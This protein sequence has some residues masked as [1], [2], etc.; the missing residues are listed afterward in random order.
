M[1]GKQDF[2]EV[3]ALVDKL[4]VLLD[5]SGLS[6]NALA[7][8]A[9]YDK[10]TVSRFMSGQFHPQWDFMETLMDAV[11]ERR[12]LSEEET[13]EVL[14]VWEEALFARNGR[15]AGFR[16][17]RKT[18][19]ELRAARGELGSKLEAL[20]NKYHLL[21]LAGLAAFLLVVWMGIGWY[22]ADEGVLKSF[23]GDAPAQEVNCANRGCAVTALGWVLGSSGESSVRT[24][25]EVGTYGGTVS[26]GGRLGLSAQC[27]ATVRWKMTAEKGDG[28]APE[29]LSAGVVTQGDDVR[30]YAPIHRD[31]RTITLTAQRGDSRSCDAV[32][33][34]R[35]SEPRVHWPAPSPKDRGIPTPAALKP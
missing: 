23:S 12:E 8:L 18:L 25:F 2:P 15:S 13:A 20:N 16:T 9:G 3:Q 11:R 6:Q 1:A 30:L 33:V 17:V 4:A 19:V 5:E 32:L 10:S 7:R 24:V 22:T 31:V 14:S 21:V 26:L 28:A 34:W 35:A 29:E 27:G